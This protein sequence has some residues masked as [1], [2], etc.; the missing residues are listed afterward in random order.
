ML[1]GSLQVQPSL[2]LRTM[3]LLKYLAGFSTVSV[4]SDWLPGVLV[5][6]HADGALSERH[7]SCNG[8]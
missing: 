8:L 7:R 2:L 5:G 4:S 6:A 3:P 1:A